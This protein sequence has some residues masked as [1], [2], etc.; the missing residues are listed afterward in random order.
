VPPVPAN[1]AFDSG[2]TFFLADRLDDL[3]V[4]AKLIGTIDQNEA[5]IFLPR[6]ANEDALSF[7]S[8]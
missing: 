5:E 6:L 7:D 4:V 1:L 2:E 8:G 3:T